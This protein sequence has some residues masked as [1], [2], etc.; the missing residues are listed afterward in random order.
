MENISQPS[1]GN[2]STQKVER[3]GMTPHCACSAWLTENIT[4]SINSASYEPQA[5]NFVNVSS[6]SNATAY[7]WLLVNIPFASDV[8]PD[9]Q[10]NGP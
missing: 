2:V 10:R 3:V 8:D 6:A 7:I 5:L 4:P 1:V 9:M